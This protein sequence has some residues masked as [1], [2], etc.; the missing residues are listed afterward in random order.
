MS[1]PSFYGGNKETLDL[2]VTNLPCILLEE[3]QYYKNYS[4]VN[5]K[6]KEKIVV[7]A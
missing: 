5:P 6:A 3:I 7:L 2:D 1:F 4:N